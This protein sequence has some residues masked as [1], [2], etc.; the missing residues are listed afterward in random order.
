MNYITNIKFK[1]SKT[2][3]YVWI[4]RNNAVV[5]NLIQ[6][7]C[8]FAISNSSVLLF[9]LKFGIA[10]SK[11]TT[12]LKKYFLS[13][14][15]LFLTKQFAFFVRARKYII[16]LFIISITISINNLNDIFTNS[17]NTKLEIFSH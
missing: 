9:V 3:W 5:L 6:S 12:L 1:K 17:N 13:C 15:Y 14:L 8:T 10:K 2:C 4:S 16:I 7:K 11:R